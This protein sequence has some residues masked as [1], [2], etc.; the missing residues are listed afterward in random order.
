[1]PQLQY[2]PFRWAIDPQSPPE[3]TELIREQLEEAIDADLPHRQVRGNSPL[4]HTDYP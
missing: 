1:M 2:G 4:R 3:I